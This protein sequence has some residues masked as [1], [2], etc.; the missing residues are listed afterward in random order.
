MQ[1]SS[2]API[3]AYTSFLSNELLSGVKLTDSVGAQ[4]EI[5]RVLANSL[6]PSLSANSDMR[7]REV[8]IFASSLARLAWMES[9]LFGL[10]AW[11]MR[12]GLV[13]LSYNI[14]GSQASDELH[15]AT[16]AAVQEGAA[17]VVSTGTSFIGIDKILQNLIVAKSRLNKRVIPVGMIPVATPESIPSIAKRYL[18][19][20]DTTSLSR[21]TSDDSRQKGDSI[22]ADSMAV[23]LARMNIRDSIQSTG[24]N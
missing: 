2:S 11:Y 13:R 10:D 16:Q 14:A 12:M 5:Q 3:D 9:L 21:I 7:Q 6:T 1:D 15:I 18:G 4:S 22:S 23:K 20:A 17:E 24:I 19:D 8:D